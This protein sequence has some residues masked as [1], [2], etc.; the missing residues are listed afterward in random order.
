MGSFLARVHKGP[1]SRDMLSC[2]PNLAMEMVACF[3]SSIFYIPVGCCTR[4]G[5]GVVGGLSFR[6]LLASQ[7]EAARVGA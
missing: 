7:C 1:C 5:V 3:G 2:R 4:S 6:L